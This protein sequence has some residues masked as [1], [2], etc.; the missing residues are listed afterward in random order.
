MSP[1]TQGRE[2]KQALYPMMTLLPSSPLTQG[3]ELKPASLYLDIVALSSPLTQGRELK[4]I[5]PPLY[6]APQSRPSRRG[7]N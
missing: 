5:T 4:H 3:R 1:L 6:P 2:L 7:V